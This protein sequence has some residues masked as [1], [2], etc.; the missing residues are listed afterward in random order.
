MGINPYSRK[1]SRAEQVTATDQNGGGHDVRV[2]TQK[3]P[4]EPQNRWQMD[5][6]RNGAIGF[7]S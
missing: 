5:D 4:G 7:T 3:T 1:T 2:K 6:P